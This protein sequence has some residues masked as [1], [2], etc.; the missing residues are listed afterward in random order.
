M[1]HKNTL[2][3]IFESDIKPI[4]LYKIP[5]FPTYEMEKASTFIMQWIPTIAITTRKRD[6]G[7]T[8]ISA[9]KY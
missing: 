7:Q 6:W 8:L 4:L 5:I 2:F 9:L 3:F 1:S